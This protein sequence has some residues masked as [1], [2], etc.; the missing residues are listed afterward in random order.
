MRKM[1]QQNIKSNTT[2]L[3]L[4]DHV[5]IFEVEDTMVMQSYLKR[6]SLLLRQLYIFS[7]QEN[8][9]FLT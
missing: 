3:Y 5:L 7:L 8:M 6:G 2:K 1:Q 9:G 4:K